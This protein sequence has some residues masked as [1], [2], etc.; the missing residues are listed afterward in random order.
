MIRHQ[1]ATHL[2]IS[3]LIYHVIRHLNHLISPL[4]SRNSLKQDRYSSAK[5]YHP[6]FVCSASYDTASCSL[7]MLPESVSS[8]LGSC[9]LMLGHMRAWKYIVLIWSYEVKS[10][11]TTGIY[12]SCLN[13]RCWL[14]SQTVYPFMCQSNCWD[15]ILNSMRN[16]LNMLLYIHV[17]H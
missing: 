1:M 9:F 6:S 16:D 11:K 4:T 2:L 17:L 8:Y 7:C 3:Q 13:W 14:K 5:P 10:R 15:S 12:F